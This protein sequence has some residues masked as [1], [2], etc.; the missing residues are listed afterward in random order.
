MPGG[1]PLKFANVFELQSKI[2][3]YFAVTP[4][5]EWTITGMALHLDTSRETLLDYQDRDEFS[6]TVKRAKLKIECGYECDLKKH[7]RTGTIFALKNFGWRD[8]QDINHGGQ[9]ENPLSVVWRCDGKD[10]RP[11]PGPV[12]GVDRQE[13]VPGSGSGEALG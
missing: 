1:R 6:D 3:D 7:G 10:Y 2:D 4:S 8:Q 5:D 12:D 9:K 13:P 11:T